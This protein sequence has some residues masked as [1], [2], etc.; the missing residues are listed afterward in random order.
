MSRTKTNTPVATGQRSLRDLS[1]RSFG[2]TDFGRIDVPY[3]T[4]VVPNDD[5]TIKLTGKLKGATMPT[6]TIGKMY[7]DVRF[8]F[9]PYRI[10]THRPEDGK[11]NFVWDYFINKL[12]NT[13]HPYFQ[14]W[15][16]T[17]I[18][19]D[20][21]P[22][23]KLSSDSRIISDC[24]RLLSQMRLPEAVYNSSTVFPNTNSFGST[25]V[26]P[27][28]F[29]AYQRIW[30][31]RYR[32]KQLIDESLLSTYIPFPNPGSN[33]INGGPLKAWLTPRYAC[34]PK[35]YFTNALFHLATNYNN[36][37]FGIQQDTTTELNIN[38]GNIP[39][40]SNNAPLDNSDLDPDII[41][42]TET[43]SLT[44]AAIRMAKLV[45]DYLQRFNIAGTGLINRIFSR[46]GV[47]P[48]EELLNMSQYLGGFRQDFNTGD[49]LSNVETGSL[50]AQAVDNAF[51]YYS[52]GSQSGQATGSIY[53][54]FKSNEIKFHSGA[55]YGILMCTTSLVPYTGYFQGLHRFWTHGVN[56]NIN[57]GRIEYLTPEFANAGLQP[58]RGQELYGNASSTDADWKSL[59]GYSERYGEYGYQPDS[60]DG[61]LVLSATSTGMDALHLFR[62]FS[63]MPSLTATFTEINP[64]AR[65]SLDR[66]FNYLHT[67]SQDETLLDHF[68][69]VIYFDVQCHRS[70]ASSMLPDLFEDNNHGNVVNVD[71]NGSR[72]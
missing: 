19:N 22:A 33:V 14:L 36:V 60:V 68:Q 64:S 16:I 56:S 40:N 23:Y 58:I 24:R 57:Q 49:I 54:D 50:E 13:A 27:W 17:S 18:L 7:Y 61:D 26:Y 72:F 21:D 38:T 4:E 5:F 8:H 71:V 70:M 15:Q 45:D 37:K 42:G 55:E 44:T 28:P 25:R 35:D 51:N 48:K 67:G 41:G 11:T 69:R 2:T 62:E 34:W 46:F 59:F 47:R 20:V 65:Q 10:L 32:D 43:Y 6:P 30:W 12:S 63:A 53:V 3:W 39:N 31:D 52:G 9:V 29:L 66:I 1:A